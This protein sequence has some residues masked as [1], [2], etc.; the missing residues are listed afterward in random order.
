MAAKHQNIKA[1]LVLKDGI[2]R[3]TVASVDDAMGIPNC[4]AI[5]GRKPLLRLMENSWRR[6][7]QMAAEQAIAAWAMGREV[8]VKNADELE[9]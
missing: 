9:G 8:G 2:K 1:I 5:L 3:V 6:A 4:R 7:S